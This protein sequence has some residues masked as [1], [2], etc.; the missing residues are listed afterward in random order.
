VVSSTRCECSAAQRADR[1]LRAVRIPARYEHCTF[2]SFEIHDPTHERALERARSWT[3][4]YP[5]VDQGLLL[6]GGPG[7]GKTHLAVAVA[8]ELVRTK[9]ARVRFHEQRALLKALQGTFESGAD[10]RE[11]EVLR[12]VLE[13]DVLILDD[14]GAGRTTLWARDVLHDIIAH[15]YNE[16][17]TLII[18]SNLMVGD[19]PA[20]APAP[21]KG[22][23]A[24][25]T[26]KDR[27]G[28]A[29]ISRLHEMCEVVR[30]AGKDYRSGVLAQKARF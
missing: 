18:T 26:L 21:R 12:P 20:P 23:E 15:R 27:L 2:E 30:V 29:L 5:V 9:G 6:L 19:E 1:L 3:E 16:Q 24:P 7:R 10:A 25:L 8:A 11:S 28:D 13:V 14:L 4:L 17:K 22:L